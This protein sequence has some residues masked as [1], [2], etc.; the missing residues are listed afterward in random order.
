MLAFSE[1]TFLDLLYHKD[2]PQLEKSLNILSKFN[3]SSFS[4]LPKSLLDNIEEI[5]AAN[6]FETENGSYS[7]ILYSISAAK[8]KLERELD[9]ITCSFDKSVLP[10]IRQSGIQKITTSINQDSFTL[11]QYDPNLVT[12]TD[13]IHKKIKSFFDNQEWKHKQHLSLLLKNSSKKN[14]AFYLDTKSV[15]DANDLKKVMDIPFYC[16]TEKITMK[17]LAKKMNVRPRMAL[18]YLDAAEMLGLI[19]KINNYYKSTELINKLK[20]YSDDDR[21]NIIHELIKELPVVKAF[22]LYL[23]SNSKTKFTTN[24]I[25]KFLEYSTN[26]SE[27]TARRR[28][29]TISSWLKSQKIVKNK[30]E[31]FYIEDDASQTRL[32]EF[33]NLSSGD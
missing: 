27:S 19:K 9:W 4:S 26:L 29:S 12:L 31:S 24:D 22:F 2:G 16:K 17:T 13:H 30:N 32:Y 33:M 8:R 7:D 5:K 10:L 18:Y 20:K 21:D 3:N 15:P 1:S 23:K 6:L 25:A 11:T 14:N 28:A